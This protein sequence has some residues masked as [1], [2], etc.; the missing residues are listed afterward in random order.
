[1]DDC[2]AFGRRRLA[3]AHRQRR[4]L[5]APRASPRSRQSSPPTR[6]GRRRHEEVNFTAR[7]AARP[8]KA[9]RSARPCWRRSIRA[10]PSRRAAA[11]MRTQPHAVAQRLIQASSSPMQSELPGV[12]KRH[13]AEQIRR[14]RTGS[15]ADIA[16]RIASGSPSYSATCRKTSAARA[17]AGT[18]MRQ[19]R[20]L[21]TVR[22]RARG[23]RHPT[24]RSAR[25]RPP[26]GNA[27]AAARGARASA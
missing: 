5:Q 8:G 17:R 20:R 24:R 3:L 1:M 4:A 26:R 11:P 27:P 23:P 10:P 25:P 9:S 13:L 14:E 18:S 21:I 15:A 16:S 22:A 6:C 7:R 19:G 12:E 2:A